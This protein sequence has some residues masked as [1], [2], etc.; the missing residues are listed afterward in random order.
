M[1]ITLPYPS[2]RL[3]SQSIPDETYLL[4]F[5]RFDVSSLVL[6]SSVLEVHS[7]SDFEFEGF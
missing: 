4:E 6:L 1:C 7:K 2:K 5:P 3:R